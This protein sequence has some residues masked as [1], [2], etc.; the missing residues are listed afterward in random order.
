MPPIDEAT[1]T[2]V[3]IDEVEEHMEIRKVN[4]ENLTKL[5]K[6]SL[7][8]HLLKLVR[9]ITMTQ[10]FVKH[11]T[12]ELKQDVSTKVCD[13]ELDIEKMQ[14]ESLKKIMEN[15]SLWKEYWDLM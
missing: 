8:E 6:E 1:P 7:E 3:K 11:T 2:K 12:Q 13:E 9:I 4:I 10:N 14:S 15:Y 5:N